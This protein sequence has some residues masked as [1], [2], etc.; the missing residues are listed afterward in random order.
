MLRMFGRLQAIRS[1]INALTASL[2]PVT[3]AFF[4][5]AVVISLYAIVGVAFFDERSPEDFGNLSR[6]LVSMFRI[7]AGETWIEGVPI[8]QDDASVDW[9]TGLFVMSFVITVNW[10]LLQVSVAGASERVPKE[11]PPVHHEAG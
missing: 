10:T 5:M 11:V 7:A 9:A 6:G 2:I 8:L 1:I 3:N 4:I